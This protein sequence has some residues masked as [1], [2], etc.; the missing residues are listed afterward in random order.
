MASFDIFC[1]P[2][3]ACVK[4]A[5][6]HANDN[7]PKR[8][9][10]QGTSAAYALKANAIE[11]TASSYLQLDQMLQELCWALRRELVSL[12]FISVGKPKKLGGDY[13]VRLG[14]ERGLT[15]DWA[16]YLIELIDGM[17]IEAKCSYQNGEVQVKTEDLEQAQQLIGQ[18]RLHPF[19]IPI[20]YRNLE[21]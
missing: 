16:N 10:W 14:I 4:T 9:D 2:H 13:T 1:E 17:P 6:D 20:H 15:K 21:G 5:V 11:L 12:A 18:L 3:M 7:I 8:H 19:D